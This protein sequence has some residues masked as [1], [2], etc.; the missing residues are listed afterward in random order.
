MVTYGGM[1]VADLKR[2][3]ERGEAGYDVARGAWV[4]YGE[5]GYRDQV[6]Y[7]DAPAD[8]VEEAPEGLLM[9][10]HHCSNRHTYRV[11][12]S[13]EAQALAFLGARMSTHAHHEL[14]ESPIPDAW[15]KLY[16][17]LYPLCPHGLSLDLCAGPGHYPMDM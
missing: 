12:F 16:A 7:P 2:W 13:T 1:K 4:V 8:L 5:D 3:A 11:R 14:E 17:L 6:F 9:E 15:E 10:V